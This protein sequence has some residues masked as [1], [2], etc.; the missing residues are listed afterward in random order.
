MKKIKEG[1]INEEILRRYPGSNNGG[2]NIVDKGKGDGSWSHDYGKVVAEE[3]GG[4]GC[5]YVW[6]GRMLGES[7]QVLWGKTR[8]HSPTKEEEIVMKKSD[9]FI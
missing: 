1:L 8:W 4:L 9:K 6:R 2:N 7:S 3:L 5:E